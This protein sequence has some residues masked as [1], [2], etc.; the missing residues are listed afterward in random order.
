MEQQ[1]NEDEDTS[2]DYEHKKDYNLFRKVSTFKNG[3]FEFNFNSKINNIIASILISKKRP[4]NICL[5][6]NTFMHNIF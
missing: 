6:T 1:D 4:N 5:F 2:R 3:I